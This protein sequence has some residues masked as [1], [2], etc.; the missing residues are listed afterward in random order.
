MSDK[1][2]IVGARQFIDGCTNVQDEAWSG[3]PSVVSYG[4]VEKANEKIRENRRSTGMDPLAQLNELLTENGP[5]QLFGGHFQPFI[6]H[7]CKEKILQDV[8]TPRLFLDT[9]Q[10]FHYLDIL[11]CSCF[12][13][14]FN[15]ISR[16]CA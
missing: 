5:I 16:S 14:F 7:D 6:T 9:F 11:W 2:M 15:I 8:K 4:W 3:Q 1:M 13:V 12:S 10:I